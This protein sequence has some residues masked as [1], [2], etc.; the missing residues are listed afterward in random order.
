MSHHCFNRF[1]T[2]V[3]AAFLPWEASI[4]LPRGFYAK[5]WTTV[6][7]G[8]E[9]IT[10]KIDDDLLRSIMLRIEELDGTGKTA[11]C[12][13]FKDL[14]DSKISWYYLKTLYERGFI[15]GQDMSGGDMFNYIVFGITSEGREFLKDTKANKVKS[16]LSSNINKIIVGVAIALISAALLKLLS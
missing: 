7:N 4:G 12:C 6:Y 5:N 3:Y 2:F 8:G 9:V 15:T 13:E 16:W 11:Q 1:K 10:M 14:C